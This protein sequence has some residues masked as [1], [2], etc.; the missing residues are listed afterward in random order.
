M[1]TFVLDFAKE[2]VLNNPSLSG[3]FEAQ[4]LMI[5]NNIKDDA[6]SSTLCLLY[7]CARCIMQINSS[8]SLKKIGI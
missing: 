4:I 5:Y 8:L 1:Q 6:C 7:E 2:I 3:E